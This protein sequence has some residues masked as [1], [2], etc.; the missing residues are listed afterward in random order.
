MWMQRE[1]QCVRLPLHAALTKGM[2][3]GPE[4]P[5]ACD[6]ASSGIAN[7]AHAAASPGVRAMSPLFS[8]IVLV[9]LAAVVIAAYAWRVR[10][11]AAHQHAADDTVA[12][13][14]ARPAFEGVPVA[15]D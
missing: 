13:A 1:K 9:V 2:A 14:P 3:C 12:A 5:V 15:G 4:R 7:A 6:A 11:F 8:A 10:A